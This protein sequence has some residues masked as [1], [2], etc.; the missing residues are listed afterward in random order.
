MSFHLIEAPSRS[1][2][3]SSNFSPLKPAVNKLFKPSPTAPS[4]P[5][6]AVKS[7][8]LSFIKSVLSP[9]SC[10]I[11][12]IFASSVL[13][14]RV[15]SASPSTLVI[16]F[17]AAPTSAVNPFA[18]KPATAPFATVKPSA[19]S[20]ALSATLLLLSAASSPAVSNSSSALVC[21][22]ISV[23]LLFSASVSLFICVRN[24]IAC[25]LAGSSPPVIKRSYSL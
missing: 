6:T 16:A 7:C 8:H 24:S 1:F 14:S 4:S 25:L 20:S 18:I 3:T 19:A 15:L 23:L 22:S 11:V 13:Y 12:E 17:L 21:L 2:V 10:A 5:N 9:A